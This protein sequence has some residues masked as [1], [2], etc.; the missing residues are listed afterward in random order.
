[1]CAD[2]QLSQLRFL[3]SLVSVLAHGCPFIVMELGQ[4]EEWQR[5]KADRKIRVV[6]FYYFIFT[7]LITIIMSGTRH[8]RLAFEP[9]IKHRKRT[10]VCPWAL[11]RFNTF[12]TW[13]NAAVLHGRMTKEKSLYYTLQRALIYFPGTT[14]V[15]KENVTTNEYK[16]HLYPV[17]SRL[18]GVASYRTPLRLTFKKNGVYFLP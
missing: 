1:M 18:V 10:E 15:N 3:V 13:Y 8:F 7:G 4:E 11:Q 2:S 16:V 14:G 6:F 9:M 5:Q 17:S 12:T